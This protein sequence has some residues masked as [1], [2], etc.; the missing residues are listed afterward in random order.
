M[1]AGVTVIV[2][3][4]GDIDRWL[5]LAERAAGSAVAQTVPPDQV[6]V[7]QGETLARARNGA[8]LRARTE[9]LIFLDADDEL[10]VDYVR[11]M[12][13]GT[14]DL[15]KPATLGI[16]PDGVEDA[17]PIVIPARPL[18]DVN[19]IVIGAMVRRA[20]FLEVGGF[21]HLPAYEDWDLWL[22]MWLAGGE[23]DTCPEA[24][25]RVHV[26]P[27][28]RNALPRSRAVEVYHQVRSRY[29]GAARQGGPA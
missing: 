8:A 21:D 27:I 16:R 19:H 4:F 15:R 2:P 25:Y 9:W 23:I 22:R 5:P 29:I 1:S 28:G 7:S 17:A 11:A 3:L 14:G 12:L 18:M 13:A 10:D 20:L 6:I 26:N 24:I